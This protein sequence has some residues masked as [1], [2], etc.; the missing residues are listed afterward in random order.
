MPKPAKKESYGNG[1]GLLHLAAI[2]LV[3]G[4]VTLVFYRSAVTSRYEKYKISMQRYLNRPKLSV[5]TMEAYSGSKQSGKLSIKEVNGK[6]VVNILL[7]EF[8]KGVA[9]SAHFHNGNCDLMKDVRYR[10]N[11]VYNGKSETILDMSM[12]DLFGKYPMAVNVHKSPSIT[13]VSV[14]CVNLPK[15]Y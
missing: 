12:A 14:S 5:L 4:I 15:D 7:D 2:A 9:Q 1:I 11:P 6:V 10:L 13:D 8:P 3:V